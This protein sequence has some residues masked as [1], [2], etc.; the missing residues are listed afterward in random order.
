MPDDLVVLVYDHFYPDFTAGGPVRSL[1]NLSQLLKGKENLRILTGAFEY[2]SHGKMEGIEPDRWKD[3]QGVPVWYATS[4]QSIKESIDTLPYDQGVT[5]YL[6]GIFSV[7]YF[8]YPL[9]LAKKRRFSVI[10]SPRGM[11]QAG[12]LEHGSI[13]KQI[14]LMLLKRSSLLR[15]VR[16]HATDEQELTDIRHNISSTARVEVITNVPLL[17]DQTYRIE[18][19]RSELHLVYYSLI[20]KKKNLHFILNLL[21]S[22]ELRGIRLTI[23]GPVKD[24]EYWKACQ[25]VIMK[26][27]EPGSVTYQGEISPERTIGTLSEFHALVLP[28]LGE[29]FGHS[30]VEM[31]SSSRPV[32]ISDKTPWTD[33]EKYGAG[34]SLPLD[35]K[36][37]M[38]ALV[39]MLNWD[40]K[41]F[42]DAC[43]S[44]LQYYRAKFDF[45]KLGLEYMKMFAA[46]QPGTL[47]V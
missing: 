18:K 23:I 8:L 32:L 38:Q 13:K 14:Y 4:L 31:L 35:E 42:N 15:K 30:I 45:E 24:D 1:H 11:L 39:Q 7:S 46:W 9:W 10:V 12:A 43:S 17:H 21:K 5:L 47:A 40:E 26:L 37:W 25:E 34:Y 22:P 27:P 28:T 29:N 6:N 44:A 36:L 16:W 19:K 41:D 2:K 20:S 33:L 3:R